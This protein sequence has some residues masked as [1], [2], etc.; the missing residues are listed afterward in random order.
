MSSK[1]DLKA[2]YNFKFF[3]Y[4]KG[5]GQISHSNI[6]LF[7]LIGICC[8]NKKKKKKGDPLEKKK[9][10]SFDAVHGSL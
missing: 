8:L 5:N 4:K 9:E 10:S 7:T 1:K 6:V 3:V 2:R